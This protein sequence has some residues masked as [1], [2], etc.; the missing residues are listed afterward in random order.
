MEKVMEEYA[1]FIAVGRDDWESMLS[2]ISQNPELVVLFADNPAGQKAILAWTLERISEIITESGQD[3]YK[4]APQTILDKLA[5]V[6]KILEKATQ[7]E[8]IK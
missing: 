4:V 1:D 3:I 6:Q 5:S 7:R 2:Y 8:E